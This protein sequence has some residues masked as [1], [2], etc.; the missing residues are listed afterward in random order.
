ML[1]REYSPLDVIN[2]YK[3]SFCISLNNQESFFLVKKGIFLKN[4][5]FKFL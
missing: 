5:I 4:F 2:F 1:L 3:L